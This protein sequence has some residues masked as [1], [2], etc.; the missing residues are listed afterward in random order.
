MKKGASRPKITRH[1]RLWNERAVVPLLLCLGGI[2]F[3][4]S[5][6]AVQPSPNLIVKNVRHVDCGSSN[7]LIKSINAAL[8]SLDPSQDDTIFVRGACK[9]NVTITGFDRLT[10]IARA[11]ASIS[12]A[13]G[14]ISSVVTVIDSMR[15][16][17]QGFII[18]GSGP[19]DQNDGIDCIASNCTF[20]GNTV[21]GAADGVNVFRGGRASFSGDI[22]QDNSDNGLF[23]AQV[24]FVFADSVTVQRNGTSGVAVSA[25]GDLALKSSTVQNNAGPGI[26]ILLNASANVRQS[27]ITENGGDGIDVQNNSALQLGQAGAT[28]GS[29][30][31]ANQGVGILVKDLSFVTFPAGVPNVVKNNL[32]AKDVLCSPKFP[33]TRGAL[34]DIGGGTTNCVEP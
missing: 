3:S 11:G 14:G 1:L 8:A 28:Q 29:S 17:L 9:E 15:V 7:K 33:A 24:T 32:G 23:I 16:S 12:D 31:T 30:I 5:V 13:S 25:G 34:T 4:T 26:A 27:T 10:I 2:L 18:N 22:I 19:T 20:S 21:Q 6:L